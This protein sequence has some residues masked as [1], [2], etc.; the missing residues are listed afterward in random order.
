MLRDMQ[1]ELVLSIKWAVN[2]GALLILYYVLPRD[3]KPRKRHDKQ[4]YNTQMVTNQ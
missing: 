3:I 1:K 4:C 2:S